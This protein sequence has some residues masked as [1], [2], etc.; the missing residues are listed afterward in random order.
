MVG[1]C[2]AHAGLRLAQLRGRV[3]AETDL[4][5]ALQAWL[6]RKY[7][8]AEVSLRDVYCFGPPELRSVSLALR[9]MRQLETLG[10]A[11]PVKAS[12][13]QAKGLRWRLAAPG[14]ADLLQPTAA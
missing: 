12:G 6:T 7:A 5:A 3:R 11:E 9:A 10:F 14:A 4:L 1:R 13:A 2:C 8:G